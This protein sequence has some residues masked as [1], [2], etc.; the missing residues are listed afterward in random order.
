MVNWGKFRLAFQRVWNISRRPGRTLKDL[1]SIFGKD[2]V[3]GLTGD[4]LETEV[5][6]LCMMLCRACDSVRA[7]ILIIYF[8]M[9]RV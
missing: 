2:S 1:F 5:I 9:Q 8:T 4:G 7:Q 6:M 3:F